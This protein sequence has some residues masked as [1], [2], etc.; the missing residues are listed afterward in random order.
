METYREFRHGCESRDL[1]WSLSRLACRVTRAA[2]SN[3][4]RLDFTC[5]G[6]SVELQ[7]EEF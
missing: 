6:L 4:Y 3:D 2:S 7:M 1:D 5:F